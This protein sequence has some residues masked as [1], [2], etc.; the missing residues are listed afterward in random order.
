MA[1]KINTQTV[2]NL[3]TESLDEVE[4]I[5]DSLLTVNT[6]NGHSLMEI[7]GVGVDM[8]ERLWVKNGRH[9][10]V[11]VHD[12]LIFAECILTTL[13]NRLKLLSFLSKELQSP[14]KKTK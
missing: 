2:I 7:G 5:F 8:N 14:I 3:L 11:E 10:W 9:N 1:D 13:Y 4:I 6:S 12:K